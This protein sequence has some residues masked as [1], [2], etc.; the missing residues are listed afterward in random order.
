MN[1]PPGGA[2]RVRQDGHSCLSPRV[3]CPSSVAT[4]NGPGTTAHSHNSAAAAAATATAAGAGRDDRGT[5]LSAARVGDDAR[6]ARLR[7]RL[8]G[9][10]P[11]GVEAGVPGVVPALAHVASA[12][13][14]EHGSQSHQNQQSLHVSFLRIN[15]KVPA[16]AQPAQ[17][18]VR[19]PARQRRGNRRRTRRRIRRRCP[20]WCRAA[21][22]S[23]A[24]GRAAEDHRATGSSKTCSRTQP[25][26]RSR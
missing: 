11:L 20:A 19:R 2:N 4:D 17:P 21:R 16:R 22:R 9:A 23:R 7:A 15:G 3:R 25:A 26:A 5:A 6:R 1:F 13:N 8:R 24:A 14:G 12:G 10:V 18:P